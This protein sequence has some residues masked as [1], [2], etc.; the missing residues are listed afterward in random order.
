MPGMARR[1]SIGDVLRSGQVYLSFRGV[2]VKFHLI[3]VCSVY[4]QAT[5]GTRQKLHYSLRVFSRSL[6]C[7]LS[8]NRPR[9]G[10]SAGLPRHLACFCCSLA[11]SKLYTPIALTLIVFPNA[12]PSFRLQENVEI[13]AIR[14]VLQADRGIDRFELVSL[15]KKEE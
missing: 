8:P 7:V 11:P 1:P 6:F 13:K 2:K 14:A 5:S 10:I 12:L 4:I 3:P 9:L 15:P